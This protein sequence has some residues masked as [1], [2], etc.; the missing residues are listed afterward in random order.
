M[1]HEDLKRSDHYEIDDLAFDVGQCRLTRAGQPIPLTRLNFLALR[2][3]VEAAPNV[4][5]HEELATAVWGTRR[6]VTHE[7]LG[8]RIMLLRQTLADSADH[9]RYVEVVR[10]MGYRMAANVR[11]V[12]TASGQPTKSRR[13]PTP[14]S[15]PV[16]RRF[17]GR[18]V[19]IAATLALASLAAAASW[20]V[21]TSRGVSKTPSADG[22]ASIAVLPFTD[23]SV[24][25]DYGYL[26]S[27]IAD[28]IHNKL[29]E[30]ADVRV[31]GRTTS[32]ALAKRDA[33]RAEIVRALDITHVVEGSVQTDGDR[34]R[35]VVSLIAARSGEPLWSADL[36]GGISEVFAFQ[37]EIAA[38]VVAELRGSPATLPTPGDRTSDPAVYAAYLEARHINT[39]VILTSL[40]RARSLLEWVVERDR[41]YFPARREL[42][43]SY[44]IL[45]G[46]NLLDSRRAEELLRDALDDA[47]AIWPARA[48]IEFWRGWLALEFENNLPSAASH[49]EGALRD[50]VNLDALPL[51]VL[52][53]F[54]NLLNRPSDAIAIGEYLL[55]RD[56]VCFYC[57][58]NL[59]DAY[60][61][62]ERYDKVRDVYFAARALGFDQAAL[63]LSYGLALVEIDQ[64]EEA[65]RQFDGMDWD[66]F[67]PALRPAAYARAYWRLNRRAELEEALS[68]V[69][70]LEPLLT[71]DVHAYTGNLAAAFAIYAELPSLRPQLFDGRIGDAMRKY[72]RWPELAQKAGIWPKDPR[73]DIQFDISALR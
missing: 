52:V 63:T 41:H 26:S 9:P 53:G 46:A 69:R 43:V 55:E 62:A 10:G 21:Y 7:N 51:S 56:P 27:G 6:I 66:G 22:T 36:A 49:F 23:R 18:G 24:T 8:K 50:P 15:I 68:E 12:E 32:S 39:N 42:F 65:L 47:A 3:L 57:Y 19:A 1:R 61:R 38:G 40:P 25:G 13:E 5:S 70:H 71:A 72:D 60:F 30:T 20:L 48:E 17:A 73:D 11:R 2:C 4:V 34:L 31:V 35:I 58:K 16:L 67:L 14:L 33:Q 64:P 45:R 44:N 29:I 59:M 28:G 54:A 37:D